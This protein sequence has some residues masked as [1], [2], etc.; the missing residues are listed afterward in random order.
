MAHTQHDQLDSD[1]AIAEPA[2]P[3]KPVA[4]VLHTGGVQFASEKAVV[5]RALGE[6]PGVTSVECNPVAQD[7]DSRLRSPS[8]QRRR[9]AQVRRSVRLRMRWRVRPERH[10]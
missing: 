7:D 2:P 10:G 5:E 3:D 1:R 9:V 8:H 4:T 6:Q